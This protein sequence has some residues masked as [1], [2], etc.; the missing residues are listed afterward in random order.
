MLLQKIN[1]ITENATNGS[2][3]NYWTGTI[4]PILC[5]LLAGFIGTGYLILQD[6]R[7]NLKERKRLSDLRMLIFNFL[8]NWRLALK[9]QRDIL[10][11]HIEHLKKD[12][13]ED[14]SNVV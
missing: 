8:D 2:T 5:V 9:T 12:I 13:D 14:M 1:R 4:I 10:T 6:R 7:K 11:Q 3:G